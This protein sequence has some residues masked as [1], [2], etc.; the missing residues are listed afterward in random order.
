MSKGFTLL[1]LYFDI[2]QGFNLFKLD[3]LYLRDSKNLIKDT[4]YYNSLEPNINIINKDELLIKS[5]NY[6]RKLRIQKDED[7]NYYSLKEP[8]YNDKIITCEPAGTNGFY[9]L[10]V[11]YYLKK[12]Y[13]LSQYKF[14]GASAGSWNCL[15]LT[16]KENKD[17]KELIEKILS[18]NNDNSVRGF[19]FQKLSKLQDNLEEIILD[20]YSQEDFELEKLYIGVCFIKGFKISSELVYNFT[21]LDDILKCCRASSHIPLVTGN[22]FRFYHN[23][24]SIDGGLTNLPL[25]I[26]KNSYFNI[27]TGMWGR[28]LGD[29]FK[30]EKDL[31]YLFCKGYVDSHENKE[32]LDKKFKKKKKFILF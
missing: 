2:I 29:N 32:L 10:G 9:S 7:I 5:K 12:N 11:S 26:V 30:I 18:V 15:F 6:N 16:L 17:K 24:F 19:N 25:S 22:L 20:S 4:K 23:L 8:I 14:A 31:K 13:D 1:L 28:N 3:H 21:S 27:H